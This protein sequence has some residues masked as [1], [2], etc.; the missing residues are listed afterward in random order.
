MSS[1]K[2]ITAR[3]WVEPAHVRQFENYEVLVAIYRHVREN[4]Q[5]K[6]DAAFDAASKEIGFVVATALPVD[7]EI[8]ERGVIKSLKFTDAN[9][10]NTIF[11]RHVLIQAKEMNKQ[12]IEGVKPGIYPIQL[13]WFD[14]LRIKFK[15]D[16]VEPA[17]FRVFDHLFK[18]RRE[19]IPFVREPAH[20]GPEELIDRDFQILV[21][22][23]DTVYPELCF[24][25]RLSMQRKAAQE[26]M[27]FDGNGHGN[28]HA[29][30]HLRHEGLESA[31]IANR[32]NLYLDRI[33]HREWVEPAHFRQKI[34]DVDMTREFISELGSVLEKYGY[35]R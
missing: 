15:V 24:A 17:H 5:E 30:A 11:D 34:T 29:G 8:G 23:L 10:E 18:V 26:L 16:W 28:G 9:M 13:L 32:L 1:L 2:N 22:I 6:I 14:A 31:Q 12:V 35:S 7:I 25:D 3:D 21:S 27:S 19:M 20:H 33:R 4:Y